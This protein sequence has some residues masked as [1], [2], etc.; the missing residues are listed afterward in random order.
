MNNLSVHR[1]EEMERKSNLYYSILMCSSQHSS[2]LT[3]LWKEN[4]ESVR[5][6]KKL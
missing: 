1:R 6:L 5:G 4:N 2:V 3:L